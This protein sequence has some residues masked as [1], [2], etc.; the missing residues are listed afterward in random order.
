[1]SCSLLIRADASKEIGSGH[2]MRCLALA[3]AWRSDGGNTTFVLAASSPELKAYIENEGFEVFH[4][5]TVPGSF[6]D[7][8]I[9]INFALAQMAQWIVLDGY[10]FCGDY[11]KTIRTGGI[12]LLII[13]DIFHANHYYA[14]IVLNQNVYADKSNYHNFEPNTQFLLGTKYVLLRNEFKQWGGY[15]RVVP[16]LAQKILVTFGGSDPDNISAIVIQALQSINIEGLNVVIVIGGL[17][18]HYY[19]LQEMIKDYANFSL[20]INVKNMPELMGWADMAISAGGTTCWELAFMGV[21]SILYPIAKNQENTVEYFKI[22]EIAQVFQEDDFFHPQKLAK[23]ISELLYSR[24]K[25]MF[26]SSAMQS[27]VDKNGSDRVVSKMKL[28][29]YRLRK[30]IQT[31]CLKIWEWINNP[32]VRSSSFNQDEI[33]LDTHQEWFASALK[34]PQLFYYIFVEGPDNLMGQA[35]FLI[36]Q[37]EAVISVLL[38]P[39]YHGLHLGSV[40]IKTASEKFFEETKIHRISAYIK[41][42][43][44]A[45]IKSFTRAGYRIAKRVIINEQKAYHL[46]REKNP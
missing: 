9:T 43:N 15:K 31:D 3:Q 19:I 46:T 4:I 42:D 6:D 14:D 38:D 28:F 33:A 41:I 30:V 1:M 37:N 17:N 26:F 13:D 2:I 22:K 23:K 45:S 44:E 18:P 36:E 12:P 39:K 21:P 16:P 5:H 7:A 34:N 8:S 29:P 10:H 20:A 27:L 24:E 32:I 11:Q 40:L 25:R 35:R